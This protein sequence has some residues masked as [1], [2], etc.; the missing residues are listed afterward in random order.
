VRQRVGL[1]VTE[2]WPNRAPPPAVGTVKLIQDADGQWTYDETAIAPD[3]L[4]TLDSSGQYVIDEAATEGVRVV[5]L[6]GQYV[7]LDEVI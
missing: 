6:R 3:G 4:M 7:A 5:K 1:G 2:K